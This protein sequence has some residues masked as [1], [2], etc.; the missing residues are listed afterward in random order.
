MDGETMV[1]Q[2]LRASQS[3]EADLVGQRR[4]DDFKNIAWPGGFLN[5][6]ACSLIAN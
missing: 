1:S 5:N 6:G 4:V 2:H 3:R